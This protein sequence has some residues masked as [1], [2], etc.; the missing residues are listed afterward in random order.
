MK[1]LAQTAKTVAIV[2]TA[3]LTWSASARAATLTIGQNFTGSTYLVDSSSIPPDTMG[4]V[5]E[6]YIVELINGRY[7]VYSKSDGTRVDSSTLNDFWSK[8]GVTPTGPS[9]FDPRVVYDSSSERWFAASV[10]NAESDNNFLLAVSKSSDPTAGWTGF[11]IDSDSRNQR[12]ADF[13]TLGFDKD[14][15]YLAANMFQI[16][17]RGA[18]GVETTVVAVPKNNLLAGAT[19]PNFTK[20]EN[21]S[22]NT[23]FT[24]QPI[25]NLDNTGLPIPLLS[26]YNTPTGVLKRSNITGSISSPTLDTSDGFISVTP[27]GSPP[28]A[29]QP[30]SKQNL[31]TSDNSFSGNVV[32]KNGIIWGVQTVNNGDRAAQ[33]W[34]KI[35]ENTNALLQEGLVADPNLDFYYGSIAINDFNDV[36]IGVSGSSESQFV[37]SY[38]V[39]GETVAGVTTFGTPVLLKAGVDDYQRLD[40]LGR[41]RWGDYSATVVDPADP[42]RFW[43]F[44]EWVAQEDIWA[45][46]ITELKVTRAVA[47]SEPASGMGLLA[48]G[49][50]GLG[51][52]LNSKNKRK[53]V[54]SSFN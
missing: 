20:L 30:G 52:L 14:G 15:V 4:A 16:A 19:V 32:L 29:E 35:D 11:A 33:R 26:A 36:V 44:Q 22:N 21:V 38:A 6:D 50:L 7:S 3:V 47:V 1:L 46:Q 49:A 2:T 13:P 53:A 54:I 31:N 8:A 51:F 40:G 10:D 43:T 27:F 41:N 45:T 39:L 12:W 9:A 48:F 25:V 18:S 28:R 24:V 37:S 17:G 23:G 5:G 42:L 34:V